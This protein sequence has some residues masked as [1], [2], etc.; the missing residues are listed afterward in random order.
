MTEPIHLIS[1]GAGVQSSAM[2]LM[3]AHGEIEP[4]PKAAIFA[5]TQD[6]PQSVYRW[7]AWLETQLPFPVH[8]VTKGSL[9]EAALT[10]HVSS[11]TGRVFGKVNVPFYSMDNRGTVKHKKQRACTRS[12]KL[13]VIKKAVRKLADIKRGEKSH[14]VTQW[15]GISL[16]EMT[17]MKTA[18]E[19][20]WQNRYPLV[21]LRLTRLLCKDWMKLHGYPE[22]PRSACKYCGY[23]SDAEWRDLQLSEPEEFVEAVQFERALQNIRGDG[24]RCTPYLHPSCKPL[25]QIDFRSDVERGQMLLPGWQDECEGMCGL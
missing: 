25:D 16:D 3:A 18:G 21:D 7:L 1:L 23:R 19:P 6:E 4:M 13:R 11:K 14:R 20:W 15:I 24:D 9:S 22:P 5:D 2:A 10:P 8:R 12:Y 17:R